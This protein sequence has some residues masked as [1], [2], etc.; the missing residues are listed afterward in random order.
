VNVVK[1]QSGFLL[2]GG[3]DYCD[4]CVPRNGC[5]CCWDEETQEYELDEQGRH[6]PCVDFMYDE[7]G[8]LYFCG[9]P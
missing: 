5:S 7:K 2:V 4:D 8:I 9:G 6:K 3:R 1:R